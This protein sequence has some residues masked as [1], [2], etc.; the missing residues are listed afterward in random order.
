MVTATING[1][2]VSWANDYF[3]PS[4][5]ATS[6]P[7]S[8]PVNAPVNAPVVIASGSAESAKP[9]SSSGS[10]SSGGSTGGP[11]GDFER[12][13]HYEASSQTADGVAFLGPQGGG[14]SGVWDM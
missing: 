4:G 11:V 1:Q 8:A 9:S 7:T 3:G 14:G 10:Q 5:A 6:T 12:V 2:V 13:A